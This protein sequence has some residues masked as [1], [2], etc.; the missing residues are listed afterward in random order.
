MRDTL[1][2]GRRLGGLAARLVLV[3][4]VAATLA[5]VASQAHAGAAP[6]QF[7]V[8]KLVNG[9]DADTAPGVIVPVGSPV[10]FTYQLTLQ[11]AF[12]NQV[13]VVSI[14]DDN[15][16]PG[17]TGDDFS[18]TFV[19]G[20]TIINGLLDVSE[21]WVY[22]HAGIASLGLV[23]NIVSVTVN[24]TREP[25]T[26]TDPANYT[27]VAAVP[28]PTPLLVLV[29]GIIPMVVARARRGRLTA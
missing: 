11:S 29:S 17:L 18:P 16:T 23:T 25:A 13:T 27:G 9:V 26:D 20:D 2:G 21:T 3:G 19:S 10:T 5:G 8:E 6:P 15:G 22:T 24:D 4:T 28:S 7:N 1:G 14:I 12:N